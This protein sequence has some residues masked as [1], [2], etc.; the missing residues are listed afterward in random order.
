M[1]KQ[2]TDSILM[3]E[4]IAFGF[5]DET[6]SN[7]FFQQNDSQSAEMIQKAAL[8]EFT[9]M[10]E[11]LEA[12][13]VNLIVAKD[14][15]E[16]HTPDSIFPNNWISFHHDALVAKYPMYAENRRLERR[17]QVLDEVL[18]QGYHLINVVDFSDAEKEGKFL[19]GTGSMVLDRVNQK[20]Y[21]CVSERTNPE[22]VE[23]FCKA[24]RFKA[25]IFEA[26]HNVEGKRQPIYHTNVMMSIGEKFAVICSQAIDDINE[27][28]TIL[29]ELKT[30]GKEIIEISEEQMH[31]FA[32]NLLQ[33]EN[34]IGEKL[35]VLSQR[36]FES[37]EKGQLAV[38]E[39]QG[40]LLPISI[41]NIEKYG[42]GSVRCM[43]AEVF[44]PKK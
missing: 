22:V 8:A 6:A 28:E 2:N 30:D 1:I 21:A 44:L 26:F 41:P 38:L 23:L 42:G 24:F 18:K 14:T 36:A 10:R 12:E 16:P 32:G 33:I 34:K 39:K 31:C 5:N 27:R 35:I 4:P 37:L 29:T 7:N 13:G 43:L 20:S 40:K 19:E 11:I 15:K 17:S 3:I 25:L 9:A